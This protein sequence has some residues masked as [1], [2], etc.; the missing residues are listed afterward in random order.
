LIPT[1]PKRHNGELAV[2]IA[3]NES[4]EIRRKMALIRRELHQDVREVVAS[5]EAVADWRRYLRMFPWASVGVAFAIGYLIV[6][7]RK[8]SVSLDTATQA[9]LVSARAALGA[10]MPI[11]PKEEPPRPS[12]LASAFGAVAPIVWRLAQNYA[13]SYAEHWLAQQQE[14]YRAAVS[15][16]PPAPPS[17]PTPTGGPRSPRGPG[18]T[19]GDESF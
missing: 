17:Q 12:L 10:A 19:V 5:A 1:A 14:R 2:A 6:P 4:D 3:T 18:R 13:L 15:P 9:D 8:R 7:K 11:V 16:R